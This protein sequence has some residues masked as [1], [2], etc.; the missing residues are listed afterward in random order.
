M[1]SKKK[2]L[3]VF[4]LFLFLLFLNSYSYGAV[5]YGG[6]EFP[7]F[8]EGWEDATYKL[9]YYAP[10][11]GIYH[12]IISSG[13]EPFFDKDNSCPNPQNYTHLVV[14]DCVRYSWNPN[15]STEW[16]SSYYGNI[17]LICWDGFDNSPSNKKM[18]YSNFNIKYYNSSDYFFYKTPLLN[19][20]IMQGAIGGTFYQMQIPIIITILVVLVSFLGLRKALRILLMLLRRA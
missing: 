6:K 1:L 18:I 17:S 9:I 8:P 3:F 7:D 5:K 20:S 11:T 14:H 16:V 4:L 2:I 10:S 15:D 13:E 12:I 19:F